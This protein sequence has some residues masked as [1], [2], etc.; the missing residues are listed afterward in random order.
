MKKQRPKTIGMVERALI[1]QEWEANTDCAH[2]NALMGESGNALVNRAGRTLYVVLGGA[3]AAGM[4]PDELNI[5]IVRGAC[6]ALYDQ[7][8]TDDITP[9]RRTAIRRGLEA[10]KELIPIIGRKHLVDAACQLKL[11]LKQR[12]VLMS[13]FHNLV[14]A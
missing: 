4:K 6:N 1:A 7:A 2:I 3:L 13:D 5:R 11:M 14:P 9:E 8:D 10:S 12:D